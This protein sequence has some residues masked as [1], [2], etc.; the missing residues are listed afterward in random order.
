MPP[1][2]CCVP[3]KNPGTSTNVRIGILN[4]SQNLTKRA[5]FLELS[6][7]RHPASTLG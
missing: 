6:T 5:A 2:S 4:A 7:S 1:Y 3:G